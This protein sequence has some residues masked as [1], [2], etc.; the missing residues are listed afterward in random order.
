MEFVTT[1]RGGQALIH[2]G[3]KYVLNRRGHDDR[4]FWRCAK[5]HCCN[6]IN[7]EIV[8]STASEHNH[9]PNDAGMIACKAVESMKQAAFVPLRFVRLAWQGIKMT[10]PNIPNIDDFTTYFEETWLVGNFPPF[11]WNMYYMD[12]SSPRTNNHVEGWHNKL[13]RV[14]RKAYPN[15]Y[16]LIEVFQQEQADTKVTIAQ[17]AT[18]SQPPRR[19]RTTIAKD[20]KIEELKNRFRQ[21]TISLGEYVKAVSAHTHI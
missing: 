12:T 15:V 16:E 3:Y 6:T 2:E 13:K 18:G 21:D 20:R 17:L 14:V 4:I 19:G 8:S 11:L 5:S 7:D 1:I 10:A 9:P